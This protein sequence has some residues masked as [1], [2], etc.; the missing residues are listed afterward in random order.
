MVGQRDQ[1]VIRGFS[2]LN[3]MYLDDTQRTK[4]LELSMS[5]DLG[6][7]WSTYAGYAWLKGEVVR[8]PVAAIVGNT[9]PLTPR[10]SGNIWLKK[11]VGSGFY[12]GGSARYGGGERYT[13][14]NNVVSRGFVH[15]RTAVWWIQ[16]P[17]LRRDPRH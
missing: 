5:G 1:F 10:D 3:D 11:D 16:K 13:S 7:G 6:D 9:S 4:G 14:S 15:H 2:A 12:V 17:A 8:S